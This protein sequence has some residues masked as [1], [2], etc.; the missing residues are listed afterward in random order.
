M[1]LRV[2]HALAKER[3]RLNLWQV[4]WFD[5]RDP[6]QRSTSCSWCTRA[7]LIDWQNRRKPS[8]NAYR[9]FLGRLP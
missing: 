3:R 6:R 9:S 5:W 2:F 4:T 1:L 8:W 7:G